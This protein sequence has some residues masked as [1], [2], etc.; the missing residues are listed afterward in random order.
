MLRAF[1]QRLIGEHAAAEDLVHDVF[2][3]LP[4]LM[5][6]FRGQSSLRSFLVGV[7]VKLSSRYVRSASRRRIALARFAELREPPRTPP[8][9]LDQALR[10]RA[11]SLYRALDAL[12]LAQRTAYVLCEVEERSAQEAAEILGVA[13]ATVRTRCFHA[14]KTLSASLAKVL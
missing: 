4:S 12:P 13:V 11:R 2:V 1:A 8:P 14:R 3:Q 5:R 9:A 6:R 7:A 10:E